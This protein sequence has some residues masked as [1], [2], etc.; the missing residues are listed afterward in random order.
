MILAVDDQLVSPITTTMTSSVIRT[1]KISPSVPNREAMT[2]ARMIARTKVGITR[3][4]SVIRIRKE[5][6]RPPMNPATIPMRTPRKTVTRVARSPITIE[7]RAPWTVRLAML[8]PSSSVPS[9]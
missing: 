6:V 2:G 1:P 4:K 7:I 8:R 3:K 9:G 5:S